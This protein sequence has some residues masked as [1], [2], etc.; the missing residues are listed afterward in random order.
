MRITYDVGIIPKS[1]GYKFVGMAPVHD[2]SVTDGAG[3]PLPFELDASGYREQRIEWTFPRT[4]MDERTVVV[5]FTT[6]PQV[7]RKRHGRRILLSCRLAPELPRPV[8]DATFAWVLPANAPLAGIASAQGPVSIVGG[9]EGFE[10]VVH[11]GTLDDEPLSFSAAGS[12]AA[13]FASPASGTSPY[14]QG[15]PIGSTFSVL[16]V[17]ASMPICAIPPQR[18]AIGLHVC[19]SGRPHVR[20]RILEDSNIRI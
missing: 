10:C 15:V 13:D 12:P 4:W 2:V 17:R 8:H 9:Q 6:V 19:A 14:Q 7:A 1:S 20:E 11:Q 5:R 18:L 16:P 3:R